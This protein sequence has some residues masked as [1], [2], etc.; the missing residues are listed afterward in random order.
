MR[1]DTLT[2][3]DFVTL[4][5]AGQGLASGQIQVLDLG[6]SGTGA[7]AT[8]SGSVR[9]ISGPGAAA[10]AVPNPRAQNQYLL[11]GCVIGSPNCV[12]LPPLV[13]VQPQL[14]REIDILALQPQR[15][16]VDSP[17]IN[18][19]DEERLCYYRLGERE[20]CQ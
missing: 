15:E 11:N 2:A 16:D 19:F 3:P 4:L 10:I 8:L 5:L 1:L 9:N 18:I 20:P 17:V 13:P 12:L 6:L 7:T 14:V